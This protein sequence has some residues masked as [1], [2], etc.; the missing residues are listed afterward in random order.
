[1]AD[2]Q[3]GEPNPAAGMPDPT[4]IDGPEAPTHPVVP[5]KWSG[6]AAV[7]PP[8]PK[9]PRWRRADQEEPTLTRPDDWKTTTPV[10]PWA[11]QDTPWDAFPLAVEP[12][13]AP[14]PPMPPT[15]IE[16]PAAPPPAPPALPAPAPAQKAKKA[17]RTPVQTRP[18]PP[19]PPPPWARRPQAP[20]PPRKRRRWG[21]RLT[22]FSLFSVLCCCG[23]PFAYFA[24]PAARQYPVTA[25]L[26][27]SFADL[28]KLDDGASQRA[29]ER[30]AAQIKGASPDDVFAGVYSDGDGKRVTLFGVT[31]LRV[32][33]GNDVQAQL[34]RVADDFDLTEVQS[35][36]QGEFGVHE[37]C[38]VGRA[39]GRAVV[40]C[41]WADH[42]SLATVL[43][44]RRSVAESAELVGTLRNEV[45]TQG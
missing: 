34:D 36:D 28:S 23:L 15:R 30:L 24:F 12:P 31:G 42:G 39:N 3:P 40:V 29:A 32:T 41:A 43:L 38:G 1:M 8:A 22:L 14:L 4:R 26:P 20:P 6:S 19:A 11:D 45:L 5:Q 33:P 13:P 37:S 21:L 35:F 9:K 17:K 7:P 2:Q 10:D 27:D 44:T 25:V 16:P 18:G